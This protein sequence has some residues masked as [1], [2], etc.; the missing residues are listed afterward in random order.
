LPFSSFY[1]PSNKAFRSPAKP[2]KGQNL[3]ARH[4]KKIG[5]RKKMTDQHIKMPG[6]DNKVMVIHIKKPDRRLKMVS[7]I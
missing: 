7:T 3:T 5:M 6:M 4:N 2:I 1:F